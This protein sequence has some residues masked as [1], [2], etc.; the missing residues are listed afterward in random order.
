M[1]TYGRIPKLLKVLPEK[2]VKEFLEE[3]PEEFTSLRTSGEIPGGTCVKT[4]ELLK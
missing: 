2:F 3:L 1:E 4:V